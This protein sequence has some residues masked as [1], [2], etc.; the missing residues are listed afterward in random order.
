VLLFTKYLHNFK[1]NSR[2]FVAFIML[3]NTFYGFW[4]PHNCEYF[5]FSSHFIMAP[6]ADRR[7][8][9]P[10]ANNDVSFLG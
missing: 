2:N 1:A 8:A 5:G 6:A 9:S 3:L 4:C 10:L 7:T